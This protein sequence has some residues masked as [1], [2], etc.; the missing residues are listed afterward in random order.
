MVSLARDFLFLAFALGISID[1]AVADPIA[2]CRR[3]QTA[4]EKVDLCSRAI[5]LDSRSRSRERA[6]LRRGNAFVELGQFQ[7]AVDDFSALISINRRVA[8]YFDNRLQAYRSLGRYAD[9]LN[10]AETVVRMAPGQ[11]FAYRSRG[12]VYADTDRL[13]LA[14][15]DFTT[16]ISLDPANAGLYVDRG[17]LLVRAGRMRDA[18]SDFGRALQIDGGAFDAYRERGLALVR[19]GE[20][21]GALADLTLFSRT[22]PG[23]G[24]VNR[25]IEL[26]QTRPTAITP[27]SPPSPAPPPVGT[28]LP[29]PE[30]PNVAE[31]PKT[32]TGTGFF[33]SNDGYLVSN[34]HVVEGCTRAQ[35]RYGLASFEDATILARDSVNDFAILKT[36]IRPQA[37]SKLRG[38]VRVGESIAAFGFPL[39]G[40]LSSGGNFTLGNVSANAGLGDDARF[41]QISAPA[42][43]GNSGGP[44][45]DQS[46]NVIGMVVAKLDALKL[47][48]LTDDVPQNVNFALKTSLLVTFLDT[49][50]VAYAIA[51]QEPQLAPPDVA[52]RA[53]AISAYIRCRP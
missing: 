2:A 21:D 37:V 4:A 15:D 26:L 39:A 17:R 8:G 6:Y 50:G 38:G 40:L 31:E 1:Q 27:P 32:S 45:L 24:E 7:S 30:R 35:V 43:P 19:L 14:V 51:G 5:A 42:Q 34:A 13:D 11:A 23:D 44:V 46:G 41:I 10:D 18:V 20:S 48:K 52:E 3:A 29:P 9:A 28:T 12:L 47:A 16:A 36:S 33:I 49:T 25:A 53:K 22:Q